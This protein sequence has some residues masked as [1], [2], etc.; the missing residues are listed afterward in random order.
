VRMNASEPS[1]QAF[2][3][4][5]TTGR[6]CDGVVGGVALPRFHVMAWSSTPTG[7]PYDPWPSLPLEA[8]APTCATLH[9]WTQIVGKVR[10]ALGPAMNHWWQ[11]ALYVSSR[12]LT[13]SPIPYEDRTFEVMF[14]LVDH[15]LLAFTSE[16][17]LRAMPL[18]SRPVAEFH[19]EFLALLEA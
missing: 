5:E 10:L 11:V 19:A 15:N 17:R 14:D 18:L 4:S 1:S 13:T 3:R 9:M 8:W 16:G 12:G 6:V 2:F 7:N